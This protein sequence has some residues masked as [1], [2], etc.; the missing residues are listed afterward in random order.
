MNDSDTPIKT[1]VWGD[2]LG[3]VVLVNI[4]SSR[5]SISLKYYY[6]YYHWIGT[7]SKTKNVYTTQIEYIDQNVYF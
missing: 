4:E 5:I 1:K 3:Y 7:Q 2:N 6:I